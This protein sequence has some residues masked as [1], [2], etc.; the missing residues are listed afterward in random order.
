[1][2]AV[3]VADADDAFELLWED[4]AFMELAFHPA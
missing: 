2:D 4:T 3:R 1:V